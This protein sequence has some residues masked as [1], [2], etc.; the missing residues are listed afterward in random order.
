MR[1]VWAVTVAP[2][3]L[4]MAVI[5]W[6]FWPT[7]AVSGKPSVAVL[8]FNNYGGDQA[9]GRLADGLTEDIITDLAGFPEFHVIARNSTEQYRDRLATPK[10]V[11]DALGA[12][13]VVEGSIQRQSERV[14]VTAQ[15]ADANTGKHL[16]SQRWDR[17]DKDLFAIQI[18]ISEQISN[19]LGGGSGL[20]QEAGRITAHRKR[21]EN[22]NAY[23]LY[24]LGTEK[25]EQVNRA[26]VEEAVRLLTRAVEQDPGLARAWV[27]LSHSHGILAGF[28]LE[29]DKNRA[30]SADAAKRAVQ[31]DPRDAE[32][33][34]VYAITMG[35]RGEFERAKAE[36]DIA[37]RLGPGQFEVLTFYVD[38]ASTYGEP[39]RTAQMVD[40]AVSLNPSFPMWSAR[41]FTH[42]YFM[43]N[44]YEDA[45]R[46][47]DRLTPENYGKKH[48]VIRSGALSA[49]DRTEEAKASVAD[50]IRRFPDLTVEGIVNQVG[51]NEVERQRLVEAMQL[52]GFPV[53]AKAEDLAK[54]K[55][56][57]RLPEC[58]SQ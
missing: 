7:A 54:I 52:A 19:R 40:K 33:H 30:L 1:G 24:L 20:V 38:W 2:L 41:I 44:R 11:G 22:L 58:A 16:W 56:P 46:M 13:F 37:L 53:C 49:L 10:E 51:F 18:E 8:P 12:A 32:A 28:G 55:K 27:E 3:V 29:P 14:R 45:L 6:H 21:P 15:L 42:A 39:E 25:L 35:D 47:L 17:P 57:A 23:E 26:D 43:A 34:A 4:V 36:F 9:T 5:A 48:W 31:Q 50:A